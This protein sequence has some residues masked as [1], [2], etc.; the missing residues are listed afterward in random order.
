MRFG[1]AGFEANIYDFS[2][3]IIKYK[4]VTKQNLYNWTVELLIMHFNSIFICET[5]THNNA[6]IFKS[7]ISNLWSYKLWKINCQR[8]LIKFF[9]IITLNFIDWWTF[10]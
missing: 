3:I 8:F 6:F 9:V 5:H 2:V 7:S 1:F 10:V 4:I